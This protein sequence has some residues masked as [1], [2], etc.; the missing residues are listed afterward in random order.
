[1]RDVQP[2]GLVRYD[3]SVQAQWRME[4]SPGEWMMVNTVFPL[5]RGKYQMQTPAGPWLGVDTPD[6]KNPKT[7]RP[8]RIDGWETEHDFFAALSVRI[9]GII[10][11]KVNVDREL[12]SLFGGPVIGFS[13]TVS[14]KGAPDE[15][16]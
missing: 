7:W 8:T 16:H 3:D 5:A 4:I 14:G 10:N 1:M 13:D 15:E 11:E 12:K 9:L 6:Q 2:V